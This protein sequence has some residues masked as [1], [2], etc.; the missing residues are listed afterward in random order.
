MACQLILSYRQVVCPT[1]MSFNVVIPSTRPIMSL[2]D[3]RA[4]N[5]GRFMTATNDNHQCPCA[6]RI[7]K[8]QLLRFCVSRLGTI[9]RYRDW[10]AS[11]HCCQSNWQYA[12]TPNHLRLW[13]IFEEN[14]YQFWINSGQSC[15]YSCSGG[16]TTRAT[17]VQDCSSTISII[18]LSNRISFVY[19]HNINDDNMVLIL[20]H[21]FYFWQKYTFWKL[22]IGYEGTHT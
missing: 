9:L 14:L 20:L 6:K 7:L 10:E 3:I 5:N 1:E 12:V 8:A 11:N 4:E 21:Y 2:W 16:E 15:S 13:E 18:C 17:V 19:F 22:L